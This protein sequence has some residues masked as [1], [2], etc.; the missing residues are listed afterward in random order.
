MQLPDPRSPEVQGQ[1]RLLPQPFDAGEL[2]G[3]QLL[4]TGGTGFFGYWL[5]SLLDC[6]HQ[7]GVNLQARVLS[8][9]PDAFLA[10]APYFS[11]RKWLS[12]INGDTKDFETRDHAQW[13]IHAAT[14]THAQAHANPIGIME[15]VV[16]GTRHTL[17]VGTRIGVKRALYVSSGAV[18]G[19]QPVDLPSFREDSRLACDASHPG[20]AYGEAKRMAEQW[21]VQHGLQHGMSIPIARCFAFVGAGLELDGHFAIGNFIADAVAGRPITIKGDGSP[22]RS[23]LYGADLAIWLL[24]CLLRGQHGRTYNVGSNLPLS[25]LELAQQV[26]RTLKNEA[27][28]SINATQVGSAVD[29]HRYLPDTE[30]AQTELGLATWTPLDQAIRFTAQWADPT[31]ANPP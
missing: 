8:R 20:N 4:I 12:W 23:Y 1:L 24:T 25:I 7:Q 29:R 19:P 3:Q 27:G 13:L 9:R 30:R 5:L 14:D 26:N 2:D 21:C 17:H 6:L 22:M 28:L 11:N 15:D 10:K 16:L 18:Y 31:R